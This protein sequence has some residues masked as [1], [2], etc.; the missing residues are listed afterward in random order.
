MIRHWLCPAILAVAFVAGAGPRTARAHPLGG[1]TI[2]RYVHI[3]NYRDTV[4]LT[5]IMDFDWQATATLLPYAD[6]DHDGQ[7]SP[8]ELNAWSES[9][10][11]TY[12]YAL[13][14]VAANLRSEAVARTAALKF[15]N[16]AN[17]FATAKL[18][19]VYD[20]PLPPTLSG[21][22]NLEFEDFNFEDNQ[23][24]KEIV[25]TGSEGAV[26]D[27]PAEFMVERSAQLE[28][29]PPADRA[30]PPSQDH[31]TWTWV[32]GTGEPAPPPG[33]PDLPQGLSLKSPS[34]VATPDG[35]GGRL[36]YFDPRLVVLVALGCVVTVIIQPLLAR[37]RRP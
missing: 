27:V 37:Q 18:T 35:D 36:S 4:R 32:A 29:Y 13:Q 3:E 23:V 19:L 24:W 14:V 10:Q 33:H 28:S 9:V 15:R 26:V 30:T 8:A 21:T 7:E 17:G 25:L 2:N 12:G 1:V 5:Y 6:T 22:V 20:A 11:T 16:D 34:P 31:A